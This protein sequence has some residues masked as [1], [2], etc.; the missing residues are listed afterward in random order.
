MSSP[1]QSPSPT[2]RSTARGKGAGGNGYV[3]GSKLYNSWIHNNDIRNIRHLALQWSA[4]GNIVEHNTL[5]VDMNFHG[6]WERNNLV[7][8]N[9]IAVPYEH[10]SWSNGAPESGSTWQPIWVGSGDHASK[11]SGPTGP[12]NVLTNNTLEKAKSSGESI[13]R[14]GLFDEPD[15]EYALNWDG[16]Q[17]KHLNIN[18]EPIATWNQALAEGVHQQIP[19]SGV[20]VAGGSWPPEGSIQRSLLIQSIHLYLKGVMSSPNIVGGRK[21]SWT[22]P[23]QAV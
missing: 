17:Y 11:W 1:K 21:W 13:T 14:W 4:T 6:G 22:Y 12:N 10:R 9:H 3:R 18:E 5:N 15:V 19:T 2:A 16:S 20:T 7:R 23:K 8:L